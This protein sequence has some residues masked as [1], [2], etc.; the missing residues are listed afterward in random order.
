M[1]P[2]VR[3]VV[4]GA[5]MRKQLVLAGVALLLM[6]A[7][8]AEA[9]DR[10]RVL[11]GIQGGTSRVSAGGPRKDLF[12]QQ[13]RLLDTRLAR[14]YENSSRLTPRG[15]QSATTSSSG[16]IPRYAGR[17]RGEWLEAAK[18]AA[19][20]HGIPE[21]LFARLVQRESG[22]NAAAVSHKGATGLAQL[23]PGTARMLGV[24]ISDPHQ[25]L[26][27]GARYLKMMHGKFGNWRHA[28]AAYNAGPGAVE[29]HGGVPPYAETQAYV[30][31]ILGN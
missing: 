28:L 9:Q 1:M 19:R 27:G 11:G 22:F 3:L 30:V 29:K 25:N 6:G 7:G 23:M 5:L 4:W 13:T 18:A 21:D 24:D 8:V 2:Q 10:A 17:Y 26:D 31:A 16:M 15:R 12:S 14:Q 20:R